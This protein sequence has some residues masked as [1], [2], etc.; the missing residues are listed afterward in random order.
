G[1]EIV[2]TTGQGEHAYS[3]VDVARRS[4]VD[5]AA[6]TG[7]GNMLLLVTATGGD[8]PDGRLVV[9]AELTSVVH[10]AGVP[11]EH[12]TTTAELGLHGSTRSAT[13]LVIWTLVLAVLVILVFPASRRVGARVSWL[14]FGPT[15]LVVL[16]QVFHQLALLLPSAT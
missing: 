8:S 3:V 13:A 2:V 7:E 15:F 11:V 10:P 9:R 1:D 4:A 16:L 14:V 12:S 6:F 5:E